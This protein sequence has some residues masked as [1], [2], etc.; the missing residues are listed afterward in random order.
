MINWKRVWKGIRS[1]D[2]YDPDFQY[3]ADCWEF[4]ICPCVFAAM[5]V[6]YLCA[7]TYAFF[8]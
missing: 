2:F 4:K 8:W 1:N 5:L 3:M 7:I 6:T